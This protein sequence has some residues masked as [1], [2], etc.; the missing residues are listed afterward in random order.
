MKWNLEL[1]SPDR[2]LEL[3][4]E[5]RPLLKKSCKSNDVGVTDITPEDIYMLALVGVCVIFNATLDGKTTCVIAVQ[6][7]ETNGHRGADIIA[8]AG[9]NLMTVKSLYWDH[10]LDWLKQNKV[11]FVDV[12]ANERLAGVYEESFGFDRSCVMLRKVL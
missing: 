6:F 1:L 4:E 2:V 7:T 9:K 5:L 8:L 10:I 12:Y 3:W 11:E